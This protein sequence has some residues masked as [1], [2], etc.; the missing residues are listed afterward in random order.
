MIVLKNMV[1]DHE[2]TVESE[3]VEESIKSLPKGKADGVDGLQYEHLIYAYR[4]LSISPANLF[5][6]MLRASY[7]HNDLKRRVISTLH[8]GGNKR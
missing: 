3:Q 7:V 8:K 4:P 5:S 2:T 1:I 6:S